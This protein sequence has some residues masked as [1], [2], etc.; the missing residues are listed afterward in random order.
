MVSRL[1]IEVRVVSKEI[2]KPIPGHSDYDVSNL[3]RVRSWKV[4]NSKARAETPKILSTPPDSKGYLQV[5][6]SNNGQEHAR[7]HKLVMLAFVGPCPEGMEVCHEDNNPANSRLDNLRY[8]THAGNMKDRLRQ[9]DGLTL[10]EF[11]LKNRIAR[12][13][14]KAK[15]IVAIREEFATTGITLAKLA[16]KNNL[17]IGGVSHIVKGLRHAKVSGP[18]VPTIEQ[19]SPKQRYERVKAIRE[20]YARGG[21]RY[22][23]LAEKYN[24]SISCISRIVKGLRYKYVG[25]PI[26]VKT[27]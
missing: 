1:E 27:N 17:T 9:R 4:R 15:T 20:E 25:G 11:K 2:W 6:L 13:E 19:E 24:L 14:T 18:I 21:I 16:R 5:T 12:E 26:K 8:D 23:E 10:A 3:G 7:V 22:R